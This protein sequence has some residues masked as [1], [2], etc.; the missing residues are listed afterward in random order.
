[1]VEQCDPLSFA[2]TVR[3]DDDDDDDD[4][5]TPLPAVPQKKRDFEFSRLPPRLVGRVKPKDGSFDFSFSRLPARLMGRVRAATTRH[6]GDYG[7]GWEIEEE[8]VEVNEEIEEETV[9]MCGSE[10]IEEETVDMDEDGGGDIE[11][12]PIALTASI[13]ERDFA[14][15]G[16]TDANDTM[17]SLRESSAERIWPAVWLGVDEPRT[18]FLVDNNDASTCNP[19]VVSEELKQKGVQIITPP[20]KKLVTSA[21]MHLSRSHVKVLIPILQH[22]L[23]TGVIIPRE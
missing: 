18:L 8:T 5:G 7:K 12:S 23:E 10:E 17:C 11:E 3:F 13:N 15:I 9:E 21:R 16:F 1:M 4:K 14:V 20:G 19:L 22:F 2:V 6:G